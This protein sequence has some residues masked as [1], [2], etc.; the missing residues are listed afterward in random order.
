MRLN[1]WFNSFLNNLLKLIFV[2]SRLKTFSSLK[3]PEFRLYYFGTLFSEVGSQMQVVAINW[4]IYE[5]TGSAASLGFVG[6]SAFLAIIIFS[7]PSGLL[8]DKLDRKKVLVVSQ[9]FPLFLAL[10]LGLMTF[11]QTINPI[12]IYILVFLSFGFRSLQGPARQA[13]IPQLVTKE[14]FINAFS[15]QTMS[16]QISLVL[17]PAIGGFAIEFFGG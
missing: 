8:V 9:I 12:I 10:A 17:G 16:R 5:L 14:Y 6:L 2:I 13:I 11:Y 4:Q 3:F 1:S 15:L 7:L